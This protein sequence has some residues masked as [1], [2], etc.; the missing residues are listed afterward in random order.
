[1]TAF[2]VTPGLR[3]PQEDEV[4]RDSEQ[5]R[6]HWVSLSHWGG[7]PDGVVV[8][9]CRKLCEVLLPNETPPPAPSWSSKFGQLGAL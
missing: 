5:A 3:K 9:E 2:H 4:S 8:P 6:S 7:A 1:M